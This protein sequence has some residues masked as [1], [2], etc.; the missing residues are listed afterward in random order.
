MIQNRLS[1]VM[2]EQRINISELSQRAGISYGALHK[3]YHDK[4]TGIDFSTLERLCRFLDVKVG[5]LFVYVPSGKDGD[6]E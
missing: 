4:S 2:G 1:A 6:N 5:D 3:L